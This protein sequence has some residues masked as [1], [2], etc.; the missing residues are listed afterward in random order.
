MS[1]RVIKFRAWIPVDYDLFEDDEPQ[2]WM[3]CYDLAFEHFEPIN[4]LLNRVEH[5]MQFTGTYDENGKE[6]YEGDIIRESHHI[7]D[8]EF[9]IHNCIVKFDKGSFIV[10]FRDLN[11]GRLGSYT[12]RDRGFF[13]GD[14]EYRRWVVIGNVFENPEL[15]KVGSSE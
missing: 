14:G 15:L 1:E 11:S 3:M 8:Y 7:D 10:D 2:D 4:D 9:D 5:L 13:D 6:I 12:L